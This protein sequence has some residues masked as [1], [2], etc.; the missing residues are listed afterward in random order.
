[1]GTS[2]A[3]KAQTHARIVQTAS[4]RFRESG[5]DGLSVADLMKEVG[6]TH[7]GFYKHF[8]S[9]EALVLEAVEAALA[10]GEAVMQAHLCSLDQPSLEGMLNQYMSPAHRD[11]P[12]DGCALLALSTDISRCNAATKAVYAS[13]LES[14]LQNILQLLNTEGMSET[15]RRARGLLMI[16]AMVGAMSMAR[17]VGKDQALSGEIIKGVTQQLLAIAG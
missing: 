5:V 6:L 9:R 12:A 15:Q 4:Q 1:M 16:S 2:R 3:D 10:A 13:Q 11:N 8:E 17:A 14:K 7:G